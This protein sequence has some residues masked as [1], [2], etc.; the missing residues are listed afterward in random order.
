MARNSPATLAFTWTDVPGA[1]GYNL[2]QDADPAGAFA[3]LA[4]S[5]ASGVTGI[6]LPLP[7]EPLLS[8]RVAGENAC[9]EGPR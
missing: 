8:W 1:T 4:G 9:G 6:E 2:Y 5:A 3:T 7:P